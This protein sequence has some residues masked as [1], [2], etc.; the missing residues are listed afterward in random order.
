NVVNYLSELL[1]GRVHMTE[2]GS[3]RGTSHN[4][5][6]NFGLVNGVL[7]KSLNL[8]LCAVQMYFLSRFFTFY[9]VRGAPVRY[10]IRTTTFSSSKPYAL[11]SLFF[12]L[13][14]SLLN[15]SN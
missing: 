8:A 10:L 11:D 3:N 9:L 13:S 2:Q 14:P 4:R 5:E 15:S 12:S 7:P 6:L 1:L